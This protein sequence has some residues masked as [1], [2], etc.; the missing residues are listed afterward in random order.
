MRYVF[1]LLISVAIAH[2]FALTIANNNSHP[3]SLNLFED[4]V[5][6]LY[7]FPRGGCHFFTLSVLFP[8]ISGLFLSCISIISFAASTTCLSFPFLAFQICQVRAM[9]SVIAA[10]PLLSS[11]SHI[12]DM[13]SLGPGGRKKWANCKKKKKLTEIII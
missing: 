7:R 4:R 10:A 8:C 1:S 9:T 6:T 3:R 2:R 11:T 12:K 13:K 5:C